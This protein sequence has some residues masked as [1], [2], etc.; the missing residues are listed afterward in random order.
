MVKITF[1]ILIIAESPPQSSILNETD[2]YSTTLRAQAS[3]NSTHSCINVK[4]IFM[5]ESATACAFIVVEKSQTSS[6]YG[7]LYIDVYN[8][9][10][11]GDTAE[12]CLPK[13]NIT[14]FYIDVLGIS[15]QRRITEIAVVNVTILVNGQYI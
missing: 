10:R 11:N 7:I 12:G 3:Q 8:F 4:C 14:D 5:D 2:T 15:E 13:M 1:K 6:E 9:V